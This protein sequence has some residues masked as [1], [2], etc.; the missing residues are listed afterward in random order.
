MHCENSLTLKNRVISS[1][2]ECVYEKFLNFFFCCWT[3]LKSC[4][5]FKIDKV[6]IW[7]QYDIGT[8]NEY[9]FE[10]VL[11]VFVVVWMKETKRGKKKEN[12]T[13]KKRERQTSIDWDKYDDVV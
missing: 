4:F 3:C 1:L 9:N 13:Q 6:G 12:E 5:A 11:W 8:M 7:H 10:S 2:L